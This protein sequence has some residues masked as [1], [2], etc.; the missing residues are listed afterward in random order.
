LGGF[1]LY[2]WRRS[3]GLYALL[4]EGANRFEELRQRG[5]ALEAANT[6]ADERYKQHR[7]QAQRLE[8]AIED[9]RQKTAELTR[10]LELKE[11]EARVV[12]E[13]LELQ[14]GHLEKQLI[15][16]QDL[17][18]IAEDRR[19]AAEATVQEHVL[20]EQ[21]LNLR[22]KDLDKARG[23][24]ERRLADA[25]PAEMRKIKRKIAQFDRLYAS[26]RGLKEMADERN[27]NWEVALRHLSEA[28][29]KKGGAHAYTGKEPIG[30]LVAQ[31]LQSIG[32]QLIDDNEPDVSEH[33]QSMAAERDGG[34]AADEGADS[35]VP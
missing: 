29:L 7:E 1:A 16:F 35:D 11:H 20:R 14:K 31:A 10:R 18:R 34:T 9:A 17:A 21:E 19:M 27:R 2:Y 6:K 8:R 22:I 13:K 12:S 33:Q 30:P 23:D 26:M 32:A 4:V 15:K 5:T 28:L 3:T 24:L 25:D